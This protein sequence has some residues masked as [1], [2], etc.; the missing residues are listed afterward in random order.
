[1][2][3]EL[4]VNG[5]SLVVEPV[6]PLAPKA[7]EIQ[8]RKKYS[9]PECPTYSVEAAGGVTETFEFDGESI[10]EATTEEKEAYI[11]YKEALEEWQTGLTLRLLRLFLSQGITLKLTKKQEE[12][13]RVEL[14]LL[15]IDVPE[16]KLERELFYLE[17]FVLS[18]QDSMQE[19]IQ[20]VMAETG[21]KEEAIEAAGATF[22]N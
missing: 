9:E 17:T 19:V 4:K 14:E 6:S 3:S 21:I 18:T 5:Y 1:M 22:R 12:D 2:T 10:V 8:Y 15:E 16:N 13:F 7:I 20:A 11:V